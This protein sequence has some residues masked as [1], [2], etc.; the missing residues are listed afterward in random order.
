MKKVTKQTNKQTSKQT[1]NKGVFKCVRLRRPIALINYYVSLKFRMKPFHLLHVRARCHLQRCSNSL[2][3]KMSPVCNTEELQDL[4]Q[5][6]SQICI[7]FVIMQRRYSNSFDLCA[8]GFS[9]KAQSLKLMD[10]HQFAENAVNKRKP[11]KKNTSSCNHG[12]SLQRTA[13]FHRGYQ[14]SDL[15]H[16]RTWSKLYFIFFHV[17]GD[18][19]LSQSESE[20]H[21]QEK[22]KNMKKKGPQTFAHFENFLQKCVFHV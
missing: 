4:S 17:I 3:Q 15:H 18:C 1:N 7:N 13:A 20:N 10:R 2:P 16:M 22:K 5:D 14:D 11:V 6:L 21:K 12:Q 8:Q 19:L 9:K